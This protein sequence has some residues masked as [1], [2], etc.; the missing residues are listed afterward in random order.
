MTILTSS[1]WFPQKE[2]HHSELLAT[3]KA[4][5]P[6]P[7][8]TVRQSTDPLTSPPLVPTAATSRGM[9]VMTCDPEGIWAFLCK[10]KEKWHLFKLGKSSLFQIRKIH[11]SIEHFSVWS[12]GVFLEGPEYFQRK[13]LAE[14]FIT[15][16]FLIYGKSITSLFTTA[17]DRTNRNN[18]LSHFHVTGSEQ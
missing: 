6:S 18:S 15:I 1:Y 16:K 12:F 14:L 2:I 13:P 7:V 10:Y 3:M 17:T 4:F 8:R 9:G 5:F 11:K